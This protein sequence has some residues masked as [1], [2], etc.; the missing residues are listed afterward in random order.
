MLHEP[1]TIDIDE[2]SELARLLADAGSRPLRL[3]AGTVSYRVTREDPLARADPA[4]FN[5]AIDRLAGSWSAEDAEAAIDYIY[6]ARED[7]S[8]PATRP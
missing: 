4:A 8:R 6:K 7:G 2:S 3:V 1:K 5:A